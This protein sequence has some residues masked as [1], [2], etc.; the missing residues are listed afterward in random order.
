[1]TGSLFS[2]VVMG[3]AL[4]ASSWL[5]GILPL[6][7]TLTHTRLQAYLSIAAGAMIGAVFFHMLPEAVEAGGPSTLSW[8]PVGLIFLF[9]LERFLPAH[10][11]REAYRQDAEHSHGHPL[12]DT[13]G[14]VG[15]DHAYQPDHDDHDHHGHDDFTPSPSRWSWVAALVGLSI[16]SLIGG[17]ALAMTWRLGADDGA[18]AWGVFLAMIL[19]KPADGLTLAGLMIRAR[20][21]KLWGHAANAFLA[22]T[23]PLGMALVVVGTSDWANG[24]GSGSW[25]PPLV[26]LSAGTF[27]CIA[28][29]DLLP[30]LRFHTHDRLLLSGCLAAGLVLLSVPLLFGFGHDHGHEGEEGPT[31]GH[32]H[33][34]HQTDGPE[35]AETTD[36]AADP[37]E[38]VITDPLDMPGD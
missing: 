24:D 1:M 17:L 15:H 21:P 30:E 10:R 11:H 37:D 7:S 27:L 22:L 32:D 6:A 9:L 26:A 14:D 38:L 35:P 4:V 18:A 2:L 20:L 13:C 8:T 25:L 3:L 33:P 23:G 36:P 29:S 31:P 12:G 16:H 5:G 19:H 28:L 34:H